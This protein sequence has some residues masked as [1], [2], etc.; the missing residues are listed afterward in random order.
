R[1]A[2]AR[3]QQPTSDDAAGG[4]TK[5]AQELPSRAAAGVHRGGSSPQ[6]LRPIVAPPGEADKSSGRSSPHVNSRPRSAMTSSS[7][8]T[9]SAYHSTAWL[10]VITGRPSSDSSGW[11]TSGLWMLLQLRN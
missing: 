2:T 3:L 4:D 6:L 11:T 5:G 10:L 8:R 9:R 1:G 7:P